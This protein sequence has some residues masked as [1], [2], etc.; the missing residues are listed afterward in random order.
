[1]ILT[2][3]DQDKD[4]DEDGAMNVHVDMHM[5]VEHVCAGT[6][7][8]MHA[9]KSDHPLSGCRHERTS[10]HAQAHVEIDPC[11]GQCSG[12]TCWNTSSERYCSRFVGSTPS[13]KGGRPARTS[14]G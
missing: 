12:S 1:M 6:H 3:R 8:C 4:K 9:P 2:G 11:A 13:G 14:S 7:S 10:R 5:R